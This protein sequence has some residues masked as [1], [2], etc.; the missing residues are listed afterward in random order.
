MKK[1]LLITCFAILGQ[2]NFA[3]DWAPI[4]TTEKFCYSSDDTLNI[5]NNVLWVDS[6][7]IFNDVEV[8]YLNKIA[9]LFS[10]EPAKYMYNE[11][12]FL[13]DS[14]IIYQTGEWYF[15]D[16]FPIPDPDNFSLFPNANLGDSWSFS[17]NTNASVSSIFLMEIMGEM[18]S[19]KTIS[20]SNGDEILLSRNH[21]IINWKNGYQLIG[22]EGRDLG[23]SILKFGDMFEKISINDVVCYKTRSMAVDAGFSEEYITEHRYEIIDI[24][25]YDDWVSINVY[26]RTKSTYIYSSGSYYYESITYAN[27]NDDLTFYKND[28]TEVYPNVPL[29]INGDEWATDEYII[30]AQGTYKWGGLKKTQIVH[31]DSD[32]D[33]NLFYECDDLYPRILCKTDGYDLVLIEYSQDYGFIESGTRRFEH[34]SYKIIEGV[35]DNGDTLGIIYPIDMFVGQEETSHQQN[36]LIYPS[37]TEDKLHIKTTETGLA[38]WNIFDISGR[39]V[40]TGTEEKATEDVMIQVGHLPKGVFII[41]IEINEQI[42]RK[43][44]IKE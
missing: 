15:V 5:I 17:S 20:L 23:V 24:A 18:D 3:Q 16:D 39:K 33:Y 19:V 38:N 27:T 30:S 2:I 29:N 7:N 36:M 11:P 9:M 10:D 4:N 22:I 6:V 13:L 1:F 25:K 21:G 28:S 44:F 34:G 42:I 12:Q 8:Y 43:K 32:Y 37:P 26:R 31:Y 40:Q 14:I 41:Q 35:I